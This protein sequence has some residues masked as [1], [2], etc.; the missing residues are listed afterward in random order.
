MN[1]NF[2][3]IDAFY[4]NGELIKAKIPTF[5]RLDSI[6]LYQM[7]GIPKENGKD[8]EELTIYI[9]TSNGKH[10]VITDFDNVMSFLRK[11]EG[12]SNG[13]E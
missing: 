6:I 7:K 10:Y 3:E 4:I 11:I 5:I 2:I 1:K 9:S 12:E 13:T 8:V